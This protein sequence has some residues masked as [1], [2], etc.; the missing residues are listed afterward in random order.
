LTSALDGGKWPASRFGRFIPRERT[1]G[2]DWIG[3]WVVPRTVL[4]TVVRRKITIHHTNNN[5][6]EF[7]LYL[8]MCF[9]RGAPDRDKDRII[10]V[11]RLYG[12]QGNN[13]ITNLLADRLSDVSWRFSFGIAPSI[14]SVLS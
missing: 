10:N 12:Y 5:I 6:N 13:K 11:S 9:L 3:G 8:C 7:T 1:P 4:D 2:T 14:L